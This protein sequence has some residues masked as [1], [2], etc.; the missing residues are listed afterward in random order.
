MKNGCYHIHHHHPRR[1]THLF[2]KHSHK[3]PDWILA[4]NWP[5]RISRARPQM[6]DQGAKNR[7]DFLQKLR[8]ESKSPDSP[9]NAI[10]TLLKLI[11]IKTFRENVVNYLRYLEKKKKKNF[12]LT[13]ATKTQLLVWIPSPVP[14]E[15]F[16]GNDLTVS[17]VSTE[18]Q[19]LP[20]QEHENRAIFY[21]LWTQRP[22]MES[23]E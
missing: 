8:L 12:N 15:T 7:S 14:W 2:K 9:P 5:K 20:Y 18:K 1:L 10:F 6:K 22:A 23:H 19:A 3:S 17:K 16:S 4:V 13:S 21:F 11:C